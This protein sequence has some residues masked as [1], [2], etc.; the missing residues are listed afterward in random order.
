MEQ[1]IHNYFGYIVKSGFENGKYHVWL[2]IPDFTQKSWIHRVNEYKCFYYKTSSQKKISKVLRNY[3][4]LATMLGKAKENGWQI[5][6]TLDPNKRSRSEYAW[7]VFECQGLDTSKDDRIKFVSDEETLE[8]RAPY[9]LSKKLTDKLWKKMQVCIPHSSPDQQNGGP[10]QFITKEAGK[11]RREVFE[12]Q[13]FQNPH[14]NV[15]ETLLLLENLND[16][17]SDMSQILRVSKSS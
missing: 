10:M 5:V 3:I 1:I 15:E 17:Q 9:I 13:I 14:I 7:G 4:E 16:K 12:Q 2:V 6:I 8:C 11:I